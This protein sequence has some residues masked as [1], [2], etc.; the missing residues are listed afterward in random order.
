[1]HISTLKIN[2][3]VRYLEAAAT[4]VDP[5][6]DTVSCASI[7]CEGNSCETVE[8]DVGYDRLLFS[9]GAQTTTFGTPGVEEYCNYLK[10]GS[11]DF[12]GGIVDFVR[13][14]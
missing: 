1:M 6:T 8:F 14:F 5:A 7:V 4:E 12:A 3:N 13:Q 9:V 10:Q 11:S 2:N